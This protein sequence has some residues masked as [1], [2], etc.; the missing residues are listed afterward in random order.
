MNL[1]AEVRQPLFE[2]SLATPPRPS[3]RSRVRGRLGRFRPTTV[4]S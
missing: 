3:F 1:V 4:V 2:V